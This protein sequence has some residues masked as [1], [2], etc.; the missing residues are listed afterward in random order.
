M[1]LEII[2]SCFP[3]GTN[4]TIN[5]NDQ[6]FCHCI[7]LPWLDNM[8][9][10]SCIPEGSYRIVCRYSLRHKAHL[11]L[12]NVPGRALI[13]I[14][15][16]N[17]ARAE[18]RGCIAPVSAITGQGKGSGSRAAFNRL[19]KRV[20]EAMEAGPVFITIKSTLK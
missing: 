2:R 14:H 10:L 13:L 17:D 6:F 15:P 8:P 19:L 5:I 11:L 20:T 12:K 7:E 3:G 9:L 18:L 4:G 16:A 1:K